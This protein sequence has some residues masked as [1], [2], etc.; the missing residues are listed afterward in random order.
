MLGFEPR[1]RLYGVRIPAEEIFLFSKT[2]I[3]GSG[4][5]PASYSISTG[6]TSWGAARAG[7]DVDQSFPSTTEVN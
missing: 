7:C 6:V 3:A 4:A 5:H 2:S 1:A